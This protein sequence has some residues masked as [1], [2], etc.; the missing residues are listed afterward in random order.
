MG[1]PRGNLT[2][3]QR[4]P[5]PPCDIPL[6]CCSFTGPWTVTRSSL[7]MLRR[8]AAFCRPLR[9]VLLLVSFP[10]SRSPVVG[11]LGLC[12]MWRDVPCACQQRP[13]I[14]VLALWSRGIQAFRHSGKEAPTP[15][16]RR[17]DASTGQTRR[18]HRAHETFCMTCPWTPPPQKG[19]QGK[20]KRERITVVVRSPCQENYPAEAHPSALKSVLES[21]NPRMDSEGAS[22]CTGSTARATAPSPGRPTPGVVKQDKSSGGSVDTTKTRSDP[23]RVR[24]CGGEKPMGAAKGKQSDAECQPPPPPRLCGGW[25]VRTGSTATHPPTIQRCVWGGGG[26]S[27]HTHVPNAHF[28]TQVIPEVIPGSTSHFHC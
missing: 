6:C 28:V 5:P 8:V 11:V 27:T 1:E 23:Q 25:G 21:A 18:M 15:S 7:R 20:E 16:T 3:S 13:I 17:T 22:G 14:G 26:S 9:P 2:T 12:W 4:P 24:T 10:R 19:E